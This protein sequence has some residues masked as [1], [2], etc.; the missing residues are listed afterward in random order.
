LALA[1]GYFVG[2]RDSLFRQH[3]TVGVDKSPEANR[4]AEVSLA[5]KHKYY[6][7]SIGRYQYAVRWP[8]L[9][10]LHFTRRY[11]AFLVEFL[12][13]VARNPLAASRHILH[14]GPRRLRHEL[15]MRKRQK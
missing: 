10:Y 15:Q 1:G 12:Q 9:R 4:D 11:A 3:A 6:L 8:N 7:T 5:R 14:T 13:I 2:T